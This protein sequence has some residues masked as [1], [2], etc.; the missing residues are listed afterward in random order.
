MLKKYLNPSKCLAGHPSLG[1]HCLALRVTSPTPREGLVSEITLTSN[2]SNLYY[3]SAVE[4]R[5]IFNP[6][7]EWISACRH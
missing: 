6:L 5:E 4:I 7:A 3:I 1:Q 2:P